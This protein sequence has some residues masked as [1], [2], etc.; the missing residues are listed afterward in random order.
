MPNSAE[1]AMN[2]VRARAKYLYKVGKNVGP[3]GRTRI[4]LLILRVL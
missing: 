1:A 2:Q 3:K 4:R